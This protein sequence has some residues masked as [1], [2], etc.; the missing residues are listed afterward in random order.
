MNENFQRLYE[1]VYPNATLGSMDLNFQSLLA[2]QYE[3]VLPNDPLGSTVLNLPDAPLT[4]WN[5]L[6]FSVTLF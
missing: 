3:Q 1:K 2:W 4:V 5:L 6:T